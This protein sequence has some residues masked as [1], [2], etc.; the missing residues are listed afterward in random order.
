MQTRKLCLIGGS[1]LIA[2]SILL[3]QGWYVPLPAGED[4]PAPPI[5][6]AVLFQISLLI[7]G[8]VLVSLGLVGWKFRRLRP[9]ERLSGGESPQAEVLSE[10]TALWLL[11]AITL[12][13]LALRLWRL[14]S[15]LWLDEVI[16]RLV[17]GQASALEIWVSYESSNNHLLN[18]L[19]VKLSVALWGEKEWAIRLPACLFGLAT[20]PALFWTARLA[21][22]RWAGLG[23]A[24]LMAVSYHHIFFS[25]N[26]RGYTSYLFFSLLSSGLLLKGLQQDRFRDWALYVVCMVLNFMSLLIAAFVFAAHLGVGAGV[27]L[28]VRARG[29]AF[30]PLFRRLTAVFSATAFLG[31]QL[32]SPTLPQIWVNL[33]RVYVQAAAGYAGL[34]WEFVGEVMRGLSAGVGGA[35][36]LLVLLPA[37]LV[38]TAGFCSLLRHSG[39]LCLALS[40]PMLLLVAFL[41]ARGLVFA[42]RFFLLVLLI[43]WM[44]AARGLE[45]AGDLA[46]RLKPLGSI[47][48]VALPTILI[49]LASALSVASLPRYYE[50]PK[51]A[52]RS[53][54][55]YVEEIRRPDEIVIVIHHA[56]KGYHY[57]GRERGIREGEDYFFVRSVAA[58]DALLS[59]HPEADTI[60]VTTF[61]RALRIRHPDLAERIDR[62]WNAV[63]I[64]PAT[65]GD[66]RITV[67]RSR[68]EGSRNPDRNGADARS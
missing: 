9:A 23:A 38:G 18:S 35:S 2:S 52:F 45:M 20:V 65:I 16:S 15:E 57:Y 41:L 1:L 25:Q 13:G 27:L 50:L 29:A 7:E 51:Q 49:G 61:P 43:G 46:G 28:A 56:E 67:W 6:G 54:L 68:I 53:S 5:S 59:S 10:R 11:C 33:N 12:M 14:D 42:P 22:S 24:L 17:Y 60:L 21:I 34:S 66:G 47:H 39:A 3:P 40:L 30:S 63:R 8:L 62:R 31:F 64:F 55:E 58:L 26:A 37:L 19:L 36:M 32:Y 48:R 4:S 44:S